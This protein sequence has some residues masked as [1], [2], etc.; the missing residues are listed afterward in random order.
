MTVQEIAIFPGEWV[1]VQSYHGL[2][3]IQVN[4]VTGMFKSFVPGQLP[5]FATSI[6]AFK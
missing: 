2:G 5:L 3:V 4:T 6:R 1:D